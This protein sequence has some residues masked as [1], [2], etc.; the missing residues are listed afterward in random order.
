MAPREV[1]RCS[2]LLA[3]IHANLQA[4]RACL[5]HARS[6]GAKSFA[7]LGDLVGYGADPGPVLDVVAEFVAQGAVAVKG[8]H[9]QAVMVPT[10]T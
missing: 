3:D 2:P 8:N 7:F 5:A 1:R 10:P 6:R 4:L 9:D